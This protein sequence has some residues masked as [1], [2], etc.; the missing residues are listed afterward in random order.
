[1]I[2]TGRWREVD[3]IFAAAL[4]LPPGQRP[5]WLDE[6]CEGSPQLRQAV[7]RLLAA[8]A[9][10]NSFLD[11]QPGEILTSALAGE[12]EDGERLGPYRLLR[13]LGHGGMGTVYLAVR[14][15]TQ[16]NR[17]VAVKI[18]HSGLENTALRHRFLAER[19][20][21]ARLD[22]P[23][24]ARLYTVGATEDGRPYLVMERI[25]G[26]PVDAYCDRHRLTVGQRLALFR[27]ICAAVEHAHRHL[28]VH[29]DLKPANILVTPEGEPKL[30]DFG[31]AKQLAP[32]AA[33]SGPRTR[34]GLRVMTPSYASP[35][36]VRGEAITTASDVYSLGVLLYELLCGRGPYSVAEGAPL[37]EIER[38]ICEREPERPSEALPRAGAPPPETLA[39]ARGSRPAAL[40]R[41]LAGD[42]DTIVLKALR[43]EPAERYE[44]VSRLSSDLELYLQNLPVSARPDTW[45]YRARKL[46]RRHRGAAAAAA[47][48]LLLAAGLVASLLIQSRRLARERDKARHTLSFL[49]DTF[50]EADPR[51]LRGERLTA[52]EVLEQGAVRVSRELAGQPEV[53]AAVM[54]AIG[55]VSLGLGRNDQAAPMLEKALE[56][57]RHTLDPS[58]LDVA[59][60]LRHLAALRMEQ[61]DFAGAETLLRQA[62]AIERRRLGDSSAEVA[63]TLNQL[64]QAIARKGDFR[65]AEPL[66]RQAL[67]IARRAEGPR[68][69][70]V[71]ESLIHLARRRDES[72]DYPASEA[73]YIQGLA[74]EKQILGEGNPT[75]AQHQVDYV[76]L[77]SNQGK[78]KE[79]EVVLRR[80][81]AVQR[82]TFGD[83]HPAVAQLLND[84]AVVRHGQGDF[85]GAEALYRQALVGLRKSYGERSDGVGDTLGNL[86]AVLEGEGRFAEAIPVHEEALA[87]RRSLHGERHQ[88]VAHSLLHLAQS[89]RQLGQLDAALPLARQSL[90]IL[91][92]T[93]G[94]EHPL[95]A[96]PSEAVGLTLRDQG[97]AAEAEP[98]LRR[99]VELLSRSVPPGHPQLAKAKVE[100][101]KCL[102]DLDR[103]PEAEK[104]LRQAEPV[105]A[106]QMGPDAEP[107][108]KIR[109]ALAEIERRQRGAQ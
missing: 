38:A 54:D 11:Q 27:K 44:S 108:R 31:I 82:Q 25:E 19:Q 104:L 74:L 80:S 75:F 17:Q 42:L 109:A 101:A 6:A 70:T 13:P 81:L 95:V 59:Q 91:Q 10:R 16:E 2:G 21:L 79:A 57:R 55:E 26:E 23:G 50:K 76:S 5:A 33:E 28:L 18:L 83:D 93:L 88:V 9:R 32:A 39:A 63:S 64:G 78:F 71:A 97:K 84:L 20:I 102:V 100:L 62:L 98:H 1:M 90:S 41:R 48:V 85:Q 103:L 105:L 49:V 46:L 12:A 37:Y 96:Y 58:S 22:H 34:T 73:L 51:H 68:G 45:G 43:K 35:E 67:A 56:L 72:G 40:R 87:I 53:Q 61:S 106:A 69:P 30:L 52:R 29:R 14:D 47:V 15:D 99:A 60:S 36:Q 3:R 4:D 24:I 65:G 86:G 8:D 94:P 66:H 77:L 89:K 92:A 7:E 107:V